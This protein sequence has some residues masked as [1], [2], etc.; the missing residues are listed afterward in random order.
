[1]S[2]PSKLASSKQSLQFRQ[3]PPRTSRHGK[4]LSDVYKMAPRYERAVVEVNGEFQVIMKQVT[5]ARPMSFDEI[6]E[7]RHVRVASDS[8][9]RWGQKNVPPSKK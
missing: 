6:Q 3:L 9:Q 2:K 1:M 7:R 5:E 8:T 4:P